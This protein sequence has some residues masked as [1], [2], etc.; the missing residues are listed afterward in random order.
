ML[1][2]YKDITFC[3]LFWLLI[4]SDLLNYNDTLDNQITKMYIKSFANIYFQ[5]GK[6]DKMNC[7]FTNDDVWYN[8]TTIAYVVIWI[9]V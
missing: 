2:I 1:K 4:V 9:E 5:I 8:S 7:K 6:Y 3:E